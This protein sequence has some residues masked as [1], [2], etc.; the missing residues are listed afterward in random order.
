MIYLIGFCIL[1]RVLNCPKVRH[2]STDNAPEPKDIVA[3]TDRIK[4]K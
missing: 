2:A 3:T 1:L 4:A